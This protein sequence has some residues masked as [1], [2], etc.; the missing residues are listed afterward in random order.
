MASVFEVDSCVPLLQENNKAQMIVGIK[1][2]SC[3]GFL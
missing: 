2:V 1:F 3:L